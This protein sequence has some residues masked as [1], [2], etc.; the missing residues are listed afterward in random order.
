MI[1]VDRAGRQDHRSSSEGLCHPNEGAQVPGVLYAVHKEVEAIVLH[2]NRIQMASRQ[3]NDGDDPA[4]RIG[5]AQVLDQMGGHFG[6]WRG[7]FRKELPTRV[8]GEKL[9][10]GQYQL[11]AQTR[12]QSFTHQVGPFE[13][14]PVAFTAS[15]PANILDLLILTTDD[16][17]K[18]S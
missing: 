17:G 3:G 6:D 9:G 18:R 10:G 1:G 15:K 16:H 2:G 7:L 14:G 5:I 4:W 12:L 8:T 13:N 11:E